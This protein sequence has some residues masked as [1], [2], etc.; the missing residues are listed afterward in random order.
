MKNIFYPTMFV[1]AALL[2]LA[3]LMV[4]RA[5]ASPSTVT[6]IVDSVLDQIDDDTSDGV[7]HSAANHCT[8]RA[9]I[10][11]ANHLTVPG[12]TTIVVPTGTYTLTRPVSGANGED[13]GDLNL[14][15]PL[16]PN[17]SISINGAG[18][19]STIIDANRID[20]AIGI[21]LGR[22][23]NI[24]G[25]TIRNGYRQVSNY[26]GGGIHNQGALTIID[27]VIEGN[28]GDLG[29]GIA[30]E[31]SATLDVI[32]CTIRSNVG[33]VGGGM[34]VAGPTTVRDSTI[35]ANGANL[36]GGIFNGNTLYVV[37]STI[38]QNNA[39]THGG[40]IYSRS[41][42]ALYNTS[43]IDNDADHDRDENG[44]IGGGVY[45]AAEPGTR[46]IVVNTLIAGNTILNA[47][48]YND[49][50]GMLEVYGWNLFGD[51]TGCTFS[52]N[53]FASWGGISL[54]TIGPLQDNGGPTWTHA[55]LAGSA[56]I[57]TTIDSLGC[58]NE[59]GAL[60]TTDQRGA[61]R[62]VGARC[63]VGAFEYSPPRY[64][65]LPLIVR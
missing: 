46:F 52:G 44:G 2:M 4:P 11:Q 18:A 60:L 16:S 10:M 63:D 19:A 1:A 55:L 17:Q 50:N 48:I 56:A 26:N 51:V 47:P 29:G 12:V 34:Y 5:L 21:A 45:G 59:T 22:T 65:Y 36:G 42:T 32:R 40:G 49:C 7:C 38:S 58:V 57:D 23:A 20:G 9:A 27:C 6:F 24:D 39:D 8:L 15:A 62:P 14:T 33:T 25:V 64:L 13:N 30:T 53:G 31:N 54:N 43:V 35:Y 61:P 28:Q 37:N 3:M 41:T